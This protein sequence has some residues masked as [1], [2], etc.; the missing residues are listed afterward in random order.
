MED[1][2]HELDTLE[3][4]SKEHITEVNDSEHLRLAVERLYQYADPSTSAAV[5]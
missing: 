1:I 5:P 3:K 4:F 2:I